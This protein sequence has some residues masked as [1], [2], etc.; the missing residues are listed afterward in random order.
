MK[1]SDIGEFGLI[2][3]M[4]KLIKRNPFVIQGIG[5]DC[6]VL[7]YTN[8]KDLL[9]TSDM[10]I[11]GKHFL[12][13]RH[14][15]G[16]QAKPHQIGHKAIAC[17]LS[18]IA[19]MGGVAKYAVVSV[20]MPKGFSVEEA[21]GLFR[22]MNSIASAF[23][24]AI[25]GGDTNSS[26]NLVIDVAMLGEVEKGRAILR[27]GA[28][29][30]DFIFVT[31]SLGRAT[32][33]AGKGKHLEFTPRV[34][35]ARFLATNFKINSM[36]DISDGLSSDLGHVLDESRKGCLIY[37]DLI[38]VTKGAGI[39]GALNDGEDFELLFTMPISEARRLMRIHPKGLA[40]F[41][42]I[43]QVLDN[44]GVRFIVDKKG[45]ARRFVAGGFRHF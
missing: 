33:A 43:G 13:G 42:C 25:V 41:S 39:K 6:A 4:R 15:K 2:E 16:G 22:G 7:R 29:A 23:G 11:E 1:I 8:K 40:K 10:L 19:S 9:V 3:R 37:E 20:G 26:D 17:S 5:D 14:K 18:D 28:K 12:R 24:A 34:K 32:G 27:S 35:E 45:K 38:P 36:I 30:G 44:E 21:D 31:G